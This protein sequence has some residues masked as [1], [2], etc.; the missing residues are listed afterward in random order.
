MKV[1]PNPASD[2]ASLTR[3]RSIFHCETGN[4]DSSRRGS[5][6][7]HPL[8]ALAT[9][10]PAKFPDAVEKA[11][12]RRPALPARLG[13]LFDLPEQ[14]VALSNDHARLKETIRA[15]LRLDHHPAASLGAAI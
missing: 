15:T 5:K 6:S 14:L 1:R 2:V 11:T 8:V 3:R 13:D 12:G 4:S 7:G 10:H 9:A